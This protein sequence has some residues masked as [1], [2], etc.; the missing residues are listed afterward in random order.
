MSAEIFCLLEVQSYSKSTIVIFITNASIIF[1][2]D[3]I[4]IHLAV[5][6][7]VFSNVKYS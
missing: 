1:P 5:S 2:A 3:K 6:D 7:V 4:E